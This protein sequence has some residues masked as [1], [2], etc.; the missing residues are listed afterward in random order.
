MTIVYGRVIGG[1]NSRLSTR[2]SAQPVPRGAGSSF[3][4]GTRFSLSND[5]DNDDD[6]DEVDDEDAALGSDHS[7]DENVGGMGFGSAMSSMMNMMRA[8]GGAGGE[9][10]VGGKGGR[11]ANGDEDHA[12]TGVDEYTDNDEDEDELNMGMGRLLSLLGNGNSIFNSIYGADDDTGRV[13]IKRTV[14][15]TVI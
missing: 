4:L 9:R 8:R 10:A 5:N 6:D 15:H 12:N 1:L 7:A 2:G 13:T 14:H 3:G 11:R